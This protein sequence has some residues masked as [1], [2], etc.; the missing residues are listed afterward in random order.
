MPAVLKTHFCT[1]KAP[2]DT[3]CFLPQLL[4][5]KGRYEQQCLPEDSCAQPALALL[6]HLDFAKQTFNC[7]SICQM[8]LQFSSQHVSCYDAERFIFFIFFKT[9]D[10]IYHPKLAAAAVGFR[11]QKTSQ[12]TGGTCCQWFIYSRNK[13]Q[14]SSEWTWM[15]F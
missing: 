1:F 13:R 10:D 3:Y 8:S 5:T 9:H 12:R 6:I 11:S 4:E 2:T 7:T 14:R 15:G